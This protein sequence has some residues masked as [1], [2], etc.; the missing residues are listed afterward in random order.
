ME[1]K[2]DFGR[3]K[4]YAKLHTKLHNPILDKLHS[5][6][7]IINNM[8]TKMTDDIDKLTQRLLPLT[9]L[10]RNAGEVLEKLQLVGSYILTKDGKPIAKL[11]SLTKNKFSERDIE[12]DLKKLRKLAGGFHL[13]GNLSPQK[14][15]KL[16][17]DRYE[18]M[19]P[20]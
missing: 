14:I 18:K 19:L 4:I 11:S 12:K 5:R 6:Y 16:L 20:R 13:G 7:Y 17:D 2:W 10:R 3:G 1:I 9:V 8:Q 15:N